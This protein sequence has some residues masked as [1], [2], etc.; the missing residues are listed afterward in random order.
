MDPFTKP[1]SQ[2][3]SC[4]KVA[5]RER[6]QSLLESEYCRH[7]LQ[8]KLKTILE[9]GD[10]KYAQQGDISKETCVKYEK[11]VELSDNSIKYADT[12]CKKF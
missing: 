8:Y 9:E 6:F 2:R 3:L 10:K 4:K 5:V 11:L 1:V 7:N 12:H